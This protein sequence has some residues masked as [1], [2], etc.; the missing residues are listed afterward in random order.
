MAVS[1]VYN[2]HVQDAGAR[3][4]INVGGGGVLLQSLGAG[5]VEQTG[6]YNFYKKGKTKN[7]QLVKTR[8][9]TLHCN[10]MLFLCKDFSD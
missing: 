2:A 3:V 8:C 4:S 7:F 6:V 9:T 10:P 1:E 5:K